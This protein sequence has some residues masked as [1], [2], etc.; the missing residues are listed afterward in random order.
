MEGMSAIPFDPVEP[1]ALVRVVSLSGVQ[2]LSVFD[3][4]VCVCDKSSSNASRIWRHL[5][6]EQRSQVMAE[7]V[8]HTFPGSG[9]TEQPVIS[10]QGAMRLVPLLPGDGPKKHRFA[11]AGVLRRYHVGDASLIEAPPSGSTAQVQRDMDKLKGAVELLV[12]AAE[13]RAAF[14][15]EKARLAEQRAL[16]ADARVLELEQA[17]EADESKQTLHANV[18]AMRQAMDTV[19][20]TL[21]AMRS[22]R[23]RA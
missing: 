18:A 6:P 10:F 14:A 16:A 22:K 17:L 2:Y 20:A 13:E 11:V 3:L 8:A 12:S 1:G 19:E 15:E 4:I 7:C 21:Q 5:S 23:R 9:Q